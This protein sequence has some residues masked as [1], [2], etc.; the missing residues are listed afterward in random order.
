MAAR[1]AALG[2]VRLVALALY[3]LALLVLAPVMVCQLSPRPR[4]A[5]DKAD[6]S[7]TC[8]RLQKRRMLAWFLVYALPVIGFVFTRPTTCLLV[9]LGAA[10]SHA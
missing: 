1:G 6:S 4:S 7:G 10:A 3:L 9:S 2:A 8:T 5:F